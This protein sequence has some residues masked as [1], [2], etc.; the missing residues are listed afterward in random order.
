MAVD[1]RWR[2]A[3]ARN[4]AVAIHAVARSSMYCARSSRDVRRA[5]RMFT[6]VCGT[7]SVCREGHRGDPL[8]ARNEQRGR[9]RRAPALLSRARVAC[10]I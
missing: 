6:R 2:I 3:N 5:S 7:L 8:R 1:P 9:A 4:S 10:A